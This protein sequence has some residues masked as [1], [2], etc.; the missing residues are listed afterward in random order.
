[1]TQQAS[2]EFDGKKIP[3]E[4]D[5]KMVMGDLAKKF[6]LR[7]LSMFTDDTIVEAAMRKLV[8]HDEETLKLMHYF[9]EKQTSMSYDSMCNKMTNLDILDEFREAFWAAVVNFS[10]PLKKQALLEIWKMF[11]DE[12]R[13][14]KSQQNTS[15]A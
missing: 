5:V 1:M 10:G 15:D 4:L 11:K 3:I 7:I 6:D 14:F 9:I 12:L 8:F 2:F 13:Q